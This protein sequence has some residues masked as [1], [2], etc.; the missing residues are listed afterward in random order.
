M[1]ASSD[2]VCPHRA[3]SAMV[4][5]IGS[6]Q[7]GAPSLF[8]VDSAT[9][10]LEDREHLG[11][12]GPRRLQRRGPRVSGNEKP[13]RSG[14]R[15]RNPTSPPRGA[16]LVLSQWKSLWLRPVEDVGLRRRPCERGANDRGRRSHRGSREHGGAPL[17]R[18]GVAESKSYFPHG[19]STIWIHVGDL[20]RLRLYRD[21]SRECLSQGC[22]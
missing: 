4:H 1:A 10:H 6:R 15:S 9:L 16:L 17:C 22:L 11:V 20:Y 19:K 18:P 12:D 5:C 3:V 7:S 13:S 8:G 21:F 2:Q 14:E